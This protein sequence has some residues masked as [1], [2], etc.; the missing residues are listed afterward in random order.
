[1]RN[2]STIASRSEDVLVFPLVVIVH[3]KVLE[4]VVTKTKAFAMEKETVYQTPDFGTIFSTLEA[5]KITSRRNSSR[6][7]SRLVRNTKTTILLTSHKANEDFSRNSMLVIFMM[8]ILLM[9]IYRSLKESLKKKKKIPK[10]TMIHL[11]NNQNPSRILFKM[12]KVAHLFYN[13]L[14]L[15]KGKKK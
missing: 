9:V 2:G 4:L 11:M 6:N 7:T 5:Q 14:F 12:S 8:T 1:V 15:L 13:L 10:L 3:P